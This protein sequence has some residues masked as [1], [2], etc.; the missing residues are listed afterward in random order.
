MKAIKK[1]LSFLMFSLLI[2]TYLPPYVS[3]ASE[4]IE[5][6]EMDTAVAGM[7]SNGQTQAKDVMSTR[8][9]DEIEWRYK[10]VDGKM[11]RRMG[12]MLNRFLLI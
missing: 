4:S 2:G 7:M 5:I 9:A 11:V 12:A 8:G 1:T 10:E 6:N 3:F